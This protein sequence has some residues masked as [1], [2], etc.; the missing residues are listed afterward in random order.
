MVKTK[1][2]ALGAAL[3]LL[4]GGLRG[5]GE[6]GSSGDLPLVNTQ[7]LSL[8][9]VETLA[10]HYGADD[11]ILRESE[12]GELI[13]KEYMKKDRPQYYAHVSRS[14]GT[15]TIR[16]GRR[17]WLSWLWRKARAE[18]Y[19]P[20]TFRENI[21]ISNASG[22]FSG[23][24]DLL[25]Y[26]AVDI[27]VSSGSIYLN[28]L[29]AKTVSLRVSSG[30]LDIRSIGG[31]SFISVSSGRLQ[32][33]AL[34]GEEHRVKVSSGRTRIDAIQG[35]S[36]IETSSGFITIGTLEGNAA[37]E[38]N[39]GNFQLA[40]LTG[41]SHRVT[42]SSGRFVIEKTRGK[43]EGRVSSGSLAIGNFSG[44][45]SFEMSSG[46]LNLDMEELLGDL[47]LSVSSGGINMTIPRDLSFNLDAVTKSG[48]IS[49]DGDRENPIRV[50]GNSTVLRPIGPSPVQTIYARTNS[51]SVTIKRNL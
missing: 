10:I 41:T 25:G 40:E 30:D 42:I 2:K 49:V 27:S 8:A 23:D 19:L 7:S 6:D 51:G 50:S 13:I 20:R 15:L 4:I 26:Q 44:E 14:A 11:V 48:S 36:V 35:N 17:P 28:H 33:D 38:V 37:V 5:F 46:N 16:S 1:M 21:R 32:I 31:D 43:M 22:T 39:S 18:I 3:L 24:A 9:G 12:T 29:S 34:S 45:G 47:R